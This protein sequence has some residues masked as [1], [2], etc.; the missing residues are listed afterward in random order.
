MTPPD[1]T[2]RHPAGMRGSRGGGS[3]SGLIVS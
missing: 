2:T 3:M 1:E